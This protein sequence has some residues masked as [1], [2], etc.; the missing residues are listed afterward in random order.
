MD[1]QLTERPANA[2]HPAELTEAIRS[3]FQEDP[4]RMTMMGARKFK[5]PEQTVVEA[6]VRDWPI[7]R[8][9]EGV[10]RE[11]MEALQGL[12]LAR[13]FVRSR[14]AVIEAVGVFGGYSESGPFFNV[15][16][17][18]LDMHILQG[19][20]GA[21]FAVEKQAHDSSLATFSFQFFDRAGEAAFKAFL[22]EDFP[23]VP[24]HRVEAFRALTQRLAQPEQGVPPSA[25]A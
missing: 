18:T 22:W 21:I 15:Q 11:V 20:L 7:V 4:S 8:L 19:E 23:N 1:G 3:W 12:G 13:V 2:S 14:A 17:D 5:V 25:S 10:F 6:L 24:A 16:T 9:R